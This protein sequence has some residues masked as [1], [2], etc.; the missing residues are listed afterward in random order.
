MR[1]GVSWIL[2]LLDNRRLNFGIY[3][4]FR[5]II[6]FQAIF[7][8][9]SQSGFF[10]VQFLL[11]KAFRIGFSKSLYKQVSGYRWPFEFLRKTENEDLSF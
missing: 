11:R 3:Q 6:L 1:V 8:Q 10:I 5:D 2:I 4:T 9:I 7:Q